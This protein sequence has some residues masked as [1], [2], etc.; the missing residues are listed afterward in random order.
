[1]MF[2]TWCNCFSAT[3]HFQ[4]CWRSYYNPAMCEF[5]VRVHGVCPLGGTQWCSGGGGH[6]GTSTH[7]KHEACPSTHSPAYVWNVLQFLFQKPQCIKHSLP[8]PPP[9]YTFHLLC[10]PVIFFLKHCKQRSTHG[11]NLFNLAPILKVGRPLKDQRHTL[12][13][14]SRGQGEELTNLSPNCARSFFCSP[15]G[16]LGI[17]RWSF[18]FGLLFSS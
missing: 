9:R 5:N 10:P 1:M 7:L 2:S 6:E 15:K 13:G 8:P 14:C 16:C 11:T 4:L 17:G 18:P 12:E 3:E